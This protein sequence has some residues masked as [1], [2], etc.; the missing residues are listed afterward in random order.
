[1]RNLLLLLLCLFCIA[2]ISQ[3]QVILQQDTTSFGSQMSTAFTHLEKNRV[4]FGILQDYA[5]EFTNLQAYNGTIV[6]DSTKNTYATVT[7]IYNTL[8]SGIIY[9]SAGSFHHPTVIRLLLTA[10]SLK[11]AY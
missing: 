10:L 1:M 6:A 2:I 3:A 4:P 5:M 11:E 7:D 8:V 9:N